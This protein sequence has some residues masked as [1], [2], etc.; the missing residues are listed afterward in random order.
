[1]LRA[2]AVTNNLKAT[3][4]TRCTPES[5]HL[6]NMG[7]SFSYGSTEGMGAQ[8]RNNASLLIYAH[9]LGAVLFWFFFFSPGLIQDWTFTVDQ[10]SAREWRALGGKGKNVFYFPVL[11]IRRKY[12]QTNLRIHFL[13]TPV[14]TR[15]CFYFLI[16]H[17]S[18]LGIIQKYQKQ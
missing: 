17:P 4:L 5:S 3:R 16:Y 14:I 9:F 10:C 1:M 12:K 6:L 2:T 8:E 7:Q 18:Q 13:I 11:L 15:K